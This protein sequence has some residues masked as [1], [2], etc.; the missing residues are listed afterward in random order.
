VLLAL[1]RAAALV[2]LLL[3]GQPT[4][5]AAQKADTL[6]LRPTDGTLENHPGFTD[7]RAVRELSDG[8][9]LVSDRFGL[10]LVDWRASEVITIGRKGEGPGEYV[11]PGG[12]YALGGDSTLF[13]DRARRWHVMDGPRIVET[14]GPSRPGIRMLGSNLSGVDS[15]GQILGVEGYSYTH[16]SIPGERLTADSLRV[17]LV[18]NGLTQ[19]PLEVETIARVGGR[20]RLGISVLRTSTGGA[21]SANPLSTEEQALLFPDGWIALALTEPYRV[22][23]RHP[24][25]TWD[26]GAPLPFVPV[27]LNEGEG[28]AVF[29]PGGALAEA[30]HDGRLG[31]FPEFLPPFLPDALLATADG[32]LLIRRTPSTGSPGN[33]YD[34]IDRRG[35]LVGVIALPPNQRIMGFGAASVYLVTTDEVDLQWLTRHPWP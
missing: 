25:G 9:L 18:R 22:D 27:A 34:V 13:T 16:V 31:D 24:E 15:S 29:Q 19:D 11:I 30:C 1:R 3:A 12:L 33:R 8:R 7:V 6:H 17:Q 4:G 28:C 35:Q 5:L 32:K 23:W 20:G 14:L 21:I 2:G 26:Q 10:V